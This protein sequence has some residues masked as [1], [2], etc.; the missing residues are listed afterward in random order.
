MATSSIMSYWP[1]PGYA[2]YSG[3]K[4]AVNAFLL[5]AYSL[6]YFLLP[7]ARDEPAPKI[8]RIAM[9]LYL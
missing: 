4:A 5:P 6:G 2:L 3:S 1:L 9:F 8:F 7:Q